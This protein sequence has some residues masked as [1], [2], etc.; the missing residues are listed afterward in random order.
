[1]DNGN[2][3]Q[4]LDIRYWCVVCRPEMCLQDVV[5]NE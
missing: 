4:L 3:D 1:V 5:D 2:G